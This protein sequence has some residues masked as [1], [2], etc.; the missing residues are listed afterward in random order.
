[1]NADHTLTA[2][3]VQIPQHSL[4]IAVQGSGTTS[5]G[6]GTTAYD[7]GSSVSVDAQP[8]TGW[9]LDHWELDGINVGTADP[10]SVTMDTDHTLTAVFVEIP[11]SQYQL[12]IGV[13]GSGSTS[14]AAGTASY[15]DGSTVMVDAQP[16][17]GWMLDHWELDGVDVGGA[18]PYTVTMDSDHTLT[19]VFVE[20]PVTQYTL[21]VANAVGS[22]T[23]LPLPGSYAHDD[24]TEVAVTAD[25]EMGWLL[26]HWELDGVDIGDANPY[27]VTMDDDHALQAVF[28]GGDGA[29]YV[30]VTAVEGQG[31][32]DLPPGSYEFSAGDEI[33]VTAS[34]ASGWTL[35]HWVLDGVATDAGLSL[36]VEMTTDHEVVAVF[37][38]SGI[39]S[40]DPIADAGADQTVDVD[41]TVVFDAT[42]SSDD[43]DIVT[44]EW[45]FG[46]G[47]TGT[48]AVTTHTYATP[49]S[50]VVTLTVWDTMDNQ[51]EDVLV[52]VVAEEAAAFQLEWWMFVVAIALVFGLAGV[53]YA[54]RS[55]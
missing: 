23:T 17:A 39:D 14:P 30:L 6:P 33:T 11:P 13:T 51:D 5:P 29:E 8:S 45:D 22:G 42:N 52:V 10:Y 49:G 20:V 25:P 54:V 35:D 34:P 44:Y 2:V 53:I 41:T 18:D 26:D 55:R 7:E 37:T 28:T 27:S 31:T 32:L 38:E 4:T 21:T 46:D 15:A 16:D 48:G 9:T 47:A 50:Y 3:F 40:E 19:A 36:T 1:M 12:T 24:G 43:V